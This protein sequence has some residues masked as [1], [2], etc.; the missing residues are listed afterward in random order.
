MAFK[1]RGFH[2]PIYIEEELELK[3][4]II[5][6]CEGRNTEPEYFEQY[7]SQK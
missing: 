2:K 3:R 5:I 1:D 7:L 4:V 6:S